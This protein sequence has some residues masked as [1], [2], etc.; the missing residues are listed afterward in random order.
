MR[1]RFALVA[2]LAVLVGTLVAAQSSTPDDCGNRDVRGEGGLVSV[3]RGPDFP[4]PPTS[5]VAARR[6]GLVDLAVDRYGTG[7][8]WVTDGWSI[9]RSGDHG[10]TWEVVH[11]LGDVGNP[12][13]VDPQSGAITRIAVPDSPGAHDLLYALVQDLAVPSATARFS[14][15]VTDNGGRNFFVRGDGL[16]PV[17]LGGGSEGCGA[18]ESCDLITTTDPNT[19]VVRIASPDRT[20]VF[21]S[22]NQ[23]QSFD[24]RNAVTAF[25]S[26]NPANG[27]DLEHPVLT[28]LAIDPG[29]VNRLWGTSVEDG[30]TR[31]TDGARTFQR[32]PTFVHF[33]LPLEAVRF[34]ANTRFE[35]R[36]LVAVGGR[37]A[38]GTERLALSADDGTT[39]LPYA[40][41]A[42]P[43]VLTDLA[44]AEDGL[45]VAATEQGLFLR[46][47]GHP[48][49][50]LNGAEVR[51][52][53]A[54]QVG[55]L[56]GAVFAAEPERL[57]VWG[58]SDVGIVNVRLGR[59][60]ASPTLPDL[61]DFGPPLDV[62]DLLRVT[63]LTP[64]TLEG[65]AR[66]D[67]QIGQ[68]RDLDFLLQVP[69]TDIPVDLFFLLDE[70]G[71]MQDEFDALALAVVRIAEDVRD[72]G[73]D[74]QAGFGTYGNGRRYHLY[75][76]IQ[77][78]TEALA[79]RLDDVR[80]GG[81][82]EVAYTGL[83]EM[84]TGEGLSASSAAGGVRAGQH[85][86]WRD[87]TVRMVIH[88]TD[89]ELRVE[90]EG[91][92]AEEAVAK[93]QSEGVQHLGLIAFDGLTT[94]EQIQ[95]YGR[96]ANWDAMFDLAAATGAVAPPSGVDCDGDGINE[97]PPNDPIACFLSPATTDQ[98]LDAARRADL[99]PDLGSVIVAMLEAFRTE[100]TVQFNRSPSP[101]LTV[102]A[103]TVRA[104][105]VDL[106]RRVDL[107]ARARAICTESLAGT[108]SAISLSASTGTRVLGGT[109]LTV[110]CG[111]PGVVP[112]PA[113][114]AQPAAVAVAQSPISPPAPI[115]APS[116]SQ[117]A[118][119]SGVQSTAA[120]NSF[121]P[122][123]GAAAA[124]QEQQQVQAA[125]LGRS[126]QQ[127]Q[128]GIAYEFSAR[129]QVDPATV[130]VGIGALF[131]LGAGLAGA[132][133][134]QHQPGRVRV[135]SG[136]GV[137]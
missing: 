97:I 43:G 78:V 95:L 28:D 89:E 69:E 74:I 137:R 113:A 33:Q 90:P 34:V 42:V 21:R 109:T 130:T 45:A 110:T 133:Q 30:P 12:A 54:L 122:Q 68:S 131:A 98:N 40:R 23:G 128:P 50:D 119:Q 47:F 16:G 91:P 46:A 105:R 106:R 13:T 37:D 92:T 48:G 38:L 76:Q 86:T 82:G 19:V 56:A 51:G 24:A 114:V 125:M 70:T 5:A 88:A 79:D 39:F 115:Q 135:R 75:H 18:D 107:P 9:A 15:L 17:N 63:D 2:L 73:V 100:G 121:V 26:N 83:Y 102:F 11:S 67:L 112:A 64:G 32:H 71:S 85:V 136:R 60:P 1:R 25:T 14:L 44:L 124:Q 55:S 10:C 61:F 8:V 52:I 111:L 62:L 129:R 120:S 81:D 104:T 20:V 4:V 72:A 65:P 126:D 35:G 41:D 7:T 29:D 87:G 84:L 49:A 66:V 27:V 96:P 94:A 59:Q 123:A 108:S 6:G 57:D 132:R 77:P 134:R 93:L 127:E 31:S 103:P 116:V 58:I 3:V 53:R 36:P 118:A 117:G 80:A 101:L 99:I 22:S